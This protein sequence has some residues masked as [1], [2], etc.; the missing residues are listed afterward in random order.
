[1]MQLNESMRSL[2]YSYSS[3]CAVRLPP[4]VHH[5]RCV[6]DQIDNEVSRVFPRARGL[7]PAATGATQGGPKAGRV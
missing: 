3:L 2:V 4:V 6:L 1:M 7:S 5:E